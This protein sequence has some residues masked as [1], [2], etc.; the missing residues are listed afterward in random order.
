MPGAGIKIF[1]K[2]YIRAMKLFQIERR[3]RSEVGERERYLLNT[4]RL[5]DSYS[6]EHI[7]IIQLYPLDNL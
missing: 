1:Q 3:G 7:I 6:L 2:F 4:H 5:V